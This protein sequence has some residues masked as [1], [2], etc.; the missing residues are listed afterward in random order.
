M[1]K[2]NKYIYAG[3][4]DKSNL[5]IAELIDNGRTIQQLSQFTSKPKELLDYYNQSENKFTRR[6]KIKNA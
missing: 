2:Q 4:K 5:L 6:Y 1:H 3:V